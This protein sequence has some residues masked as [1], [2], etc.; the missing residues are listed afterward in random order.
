MLNGENLL[1]YTNLF[2]FNKYETLHERKHFRKSSQRKYHIF[3]I[4][5]KSRKYHILRKTKIKENI[6]F[7]TIYNTFYNK[8][9]EQD[10]YKKMIR[11][12][13]TVPR[14]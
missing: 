14:G 1:D 7:S 6:I 9:T 11:R 3:L 13:N 4:F 2:S 12:L 5:L 8:S 10:N